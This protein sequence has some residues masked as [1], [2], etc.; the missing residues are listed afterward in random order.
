MTKQEVFIKSWEL[1]NEGNHEQNYELYKTLT[2]SLQD[3]WSWAIEC[4]NHESSTVDP[5][6]Y[7]KNNQ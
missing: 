3:I 5:E 1:N 6:T 2:Q 4:S 7:F